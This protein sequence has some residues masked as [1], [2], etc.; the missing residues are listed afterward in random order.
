MANW[1]NP[2]AASSTYALTPSELKARDVD[3]ITL[4]Y[5]APTNLP[6]GAIKYLRASDKFQVWNGASWV[7][8]VLAIAGG[9]TGGITAAAARTALGMSSMAT[10]ASSAVAI[11]GGALSGVSCPAS[12]IASGTVA[13]ARLGTGSGGAGALFLADDQTYRAGADAVGSTKLWFTAAAPTGYLLCDGTAV[14]RATYATLFALLGVT[15]GVGDGSTTFNVPDLRGR[16]PFGKT[17]SGT[18]ST[19]AG[20]FGSINHLH[21]GPSHT[22]TYTD[23]PNHIHVI[24]DTGHTH[25]YTNQTT[26]SA[27]NGFEI[28]YPYVD[29][30]GGTTGS[31]SINAS[32]SNPI[33]GV[34]TGTTAADGTANTSTNNP[35]CVAVNFVI[36]Y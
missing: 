25:S 3:A 31:G 20:T 15:Y 21:T 35:P 18:G 29:T 10:Q 34:A 14:S 13:Q 7:D 30:S 4:C 32:A 26:G 11:T 6:T 24:T 2:V 8:M 27:K 16:I 36:K 1:T 5:S 23:V 9:G 17:A 28:D 19:I 12:I 33:G 22:H